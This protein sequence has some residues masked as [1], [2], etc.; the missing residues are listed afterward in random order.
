MRRVPFHG[1]IVDNGD[2]VL[3]VVVCPF[4]I[5]VDDLQGIVAQITRGWC[6]SCPQAGLEPTLINLFFTNR[7]NGVRMLA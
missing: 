2:L 7:L 4:Q 1:I 6:R 3:L 5:F